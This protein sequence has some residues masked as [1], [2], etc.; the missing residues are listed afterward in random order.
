[1]EKTER[2]SGERLRD[3][4]PCAVC[5]LPMG[6]HQDLTFYILT[7]S[8]AMLNPRAINQHLGLAQMLGG[9]LAGAA[10]ADV[11]GWTRD[12]AREFSPPQSVLVMESCALQIK[13]PMELL[14]HAQRVADSRKPAPDEIGAD[15]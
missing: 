11:M 8:R 5:G 12:F 1:M 2:I 3:L 13:H 15:K 14:E 7:I 10:L 6:Q 9:G 4:G